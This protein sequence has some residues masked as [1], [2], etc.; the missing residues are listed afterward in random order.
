[1]Q[2]NF[3]PFSE[4]LKRF[5]RGKVYKS[6]C[7]VDLLLGYSSNTNCPII[8]SPEEKSHSDSRSLRVNKIKAFSSVSQQKL[9]K[10]YLSKRREQLHSPSNVPAFANN[11]GLR[12]LISSLFFLFSSSS[13]L[14]FSSAPT[15][16]ENYLEYTHHIGLEVS[17]P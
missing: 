1:M 5:I 8:L 7:F 10:V 4:S 17:S 14:T 6:M 11:F 2:R 13:L 9:L 3:K 12:F 15:C 16:A